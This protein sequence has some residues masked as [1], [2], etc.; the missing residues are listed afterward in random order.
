[1]ANL[2]FKTEGGKAKAEKIAKDI[3]SDFDK[4][5]LEFSEIGTLYVTVDDIFEFRF[6]DEEALLQA[7]R[8]CT[9]LE[10][11]K[12]DKLTNGQ[13]VVVNK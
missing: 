2:D 9:L 7:K 3:F 1:M 12:L 13:H 8:I 6:F 10:L 5:E 4:V 11:K